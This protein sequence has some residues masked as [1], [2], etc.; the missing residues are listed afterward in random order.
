MVQFVD[1]KNKER[2]LIKK[3]IETEIEYIEAEIIVKKK[4]ILFL[5]TDEDFFDNYMELTLEIEALEEKIFNYK[6][7]LIKLL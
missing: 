5:D 7:I 4:D 2:D 3:A 6:E 1:L